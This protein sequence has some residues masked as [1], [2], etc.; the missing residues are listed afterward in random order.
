[1]LTMNLILHIMPE[2]ILS[3]YFRETSPPSTNT[4]V[5]GDRRRYE[6]DFKLKVLADLDNKSDARGSRKR[7]AD[8][9]KI[10]PAALCMFVK[11]RREGTI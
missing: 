11:Q 8:K 7:I 2:P 4:Q 6:L 1:M 3:K 10:T 5:R 9:H